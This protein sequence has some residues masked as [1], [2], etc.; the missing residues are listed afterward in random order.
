MVS[1]AKSAT[2]YHVTQKEGPKR[3]AALSQE[4]LQR[5]QTLLLDEETY[6]KEYV[7]SAPFFPEWKLVFDSGEVW[8]SPSAKKV[9][10]VTETESKILDID[11]GF[12]QLMQEIEGVN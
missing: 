9:K 8:I 11:P 3:V 5:I 7:K 1:R 6:L 12:D 10:W 4:Q 2:L